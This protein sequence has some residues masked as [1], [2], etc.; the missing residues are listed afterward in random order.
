MLTRQ[1]VALRVILVAAV[2]VS[3]G[4]ALVHAAG[5]GAAALGTSPVSESI[6]QANDMTSAQEA[7]MAMQARL[8]CATR[9]GKRPTTRIKACL[10]GTAGRA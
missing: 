1:S 2:G 9:L 4:R 5:K 3:A 8:F 6:S 10:Q 7:G